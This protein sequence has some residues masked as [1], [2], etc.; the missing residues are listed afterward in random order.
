MPKKRGNRSRRQRGWGTNGQTVVRAV[1]TVVPDE[2]DVRL[3]YPI[4]TPLFSAGT[5]AS[6]RWTP[7]AAYDVDPTLGST[8][9]PGYAE[10]AAFYTYYRV[11]R[12]TVETTVVNDEAFPVTVFSI[13]TNED[14]GTSGASYTDFATQPFSKW[15]ILAA[16]G[17]MDRA[18]FKHDVSCSKLLGSNA[19]QQA[20]SLRALVNGV[21]AD[22]LYYAVGVRSGTGGV[23]ANGV[24][25]HSHLTMYVKF[26]GRQ[27]L[28]THF[29]QMTHDA[30]RKEDKERKAAA[31]VTATQA[32]RQAFAPNLKTPPGF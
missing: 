25:I 7:N 23:L 18:S 13:N 2:M 10:W 31:M 16:K 27:N 1:N 21:P 6:L 5:L 9:T 32:H 22:L 30:A 12:Y 3:I 14:P 4:D 29:L 8:S 24:Y 20:D 19:V 15:M 26:Y 11:V 28:L 17:G